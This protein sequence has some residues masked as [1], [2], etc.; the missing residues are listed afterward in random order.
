MVSVL[1]PVRRFRLTSD[2]SV[3]EDCRGGRGGRREEREGESATSRRRMRRGSGVPVVDLVSLCHIA[4]HDMEVRYRGLRGERSNHQFDIVLAGGRFSCSC[5][6]CSSSFLCS[7]SS[8]LRWFVRSYSESAMP[9]V[10]QEGN[11]E[12]GTGDD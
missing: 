12:R 3:R 10:H 8:F 4:L 1:R 11:E 7:A 2:Q 6:L 9:P 5:S